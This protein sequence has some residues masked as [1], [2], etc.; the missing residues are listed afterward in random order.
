MAGPRRSR[1]RLGSILR[2][3]CGLGSLFEPSSAPL[4]TIFGRSWANFWLVGA[5]L[6]SFF[7]FGG[8]CSLVAFPFAV[9]RLS[10]FDCRCCT[11]GPGPA[12]HALRD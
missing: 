10:L 2:S 3:T 11:W 1:D 7:A 9:D 5:V 6:V 8:R 4:G 12:D